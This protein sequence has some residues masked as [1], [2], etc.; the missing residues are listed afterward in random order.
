MREQILAYALKYRGEW[1]LIAKAI[2]NQ[3]PIQPRVTSEKTCVLGDCDYPI[4]FLSLQKPPFV[5]FYKGDIQL[6]QQTSLSIIGTRT[7]TNDGIA[8][9][10]HLVA[11]LDPNIAIVSGLAKGVDGLIHTA[12]LQHGHTCIGVVGSGL[13]TIYPDE[14]RALWQTLA[15]KHVLLS[16]YP[17]GTQPKKH[18][19]IMRNRLIAALGEVLV[20]VE[21]AMKSGTM[22]TVADALALGK[23][24]YTFPH[25]YYNP[26]GLGCNTLI[27]E[28]ANVL[29]HQDDIKELNKQLKQEQ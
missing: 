19:F 25:S 20:V 24:L 28:G 22:H 9:C 17:L 15:T 12:A 18:H 6:L 3:E 23:E 10:E 1:N 4:V 5:I 8:L 29:K 2:A 11:C 26:M 13:D 16:E 7:P 27:E 21:A 14:H